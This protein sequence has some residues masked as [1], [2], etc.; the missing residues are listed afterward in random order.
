MSKV[1]ATF[2]DS[3]QLM[4]VD[5]A[6]LHVEITESLV[7]CDTFFAG[8]MAAHLGAVIGGYC[9]RHDLNATGLAVDLN[10]TLDE[11]QITAMEA[12]VTLPNADC[13]KRLT[14]IEEIAMQCMPRDV[15]LAVTIIDRSVLRE[16]ALTFPPEKAVVVDE[17]ERK[18]GLAKK[19]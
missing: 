19:R 14:A 12:S 8:S 1:R 13:S 18:R 2:D 15:S 5:E 11:G 17:G 3:R 16:K 6:A 9:Q 7:S 10:Y 4:R